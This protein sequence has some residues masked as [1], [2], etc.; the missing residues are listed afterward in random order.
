MKTSSQKTLRALKEGPASATALA[1][2]TGLPI[3]SVK[4]SLVASS[5]N[6]WVGR[7]EKGWFLTP[8]GL[9]RIDL[10][11]E[12]AADP[13]TILAGAVQ[14]MANDL[15]RIE[16]VL[17]RLNGRLGQVEAVVADNN[18]LGLEI[19]TAGVAKDAEEMLLED[20]S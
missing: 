8:E 5:S 4:G 11:P 13:L 10:F 20:V 12:E 6:G 3:N 15:D 14:Q 16:L 2:K 7:N 1:E 9:K 18:L 17:V 19:D